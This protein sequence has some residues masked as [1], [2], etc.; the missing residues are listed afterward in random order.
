MGLW[1][2]S[3]KHLPGVTHDNSQQG[4]IEA[5]TIRT[6]GKGQI[7]RKTV[8]IVAAVVLLGLTGCASSETE[9]EAAPQPA[10]EVAE[11]VETEPENVPEPEEVELETLIPLS[12]GRTIL[13]LL[14]EKA[15]DAEVDPAIADDPEMAKSSAQLMALSW[16]QQAL[17]DG[18]SAEQKT[19]EARATLS[20]VTDWQD[21]TL[22]ETTD[23][24][25]DAC[26][27]I[28]KYGPDGL[29]SIYEEHPE[30]GEFVLVTAVV[31]ACPEFLDSI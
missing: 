12:E 27:V 19:A 25:S 4:D 13:E 28:E 5:L 31:T 8:S 26:V 2:I 22:E 14:R 11:V 21:I 30:D 10:V 17:P 6:R 16:L 1:V 23:R 3:S 15:I 29:R 20:Y 18:V 9:E 24:I 7:M